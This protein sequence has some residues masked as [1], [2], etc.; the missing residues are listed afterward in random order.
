M[1]KQIN[2]NTYSS[3]YIFLYPPQDSVQGLAFLEN[4]LFVERRKSRGKWKGMKEERRKE[5]W[6]EGRRGEGGKKEELDD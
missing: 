3:S 1:D 5:G 4:L 2:H 6:V